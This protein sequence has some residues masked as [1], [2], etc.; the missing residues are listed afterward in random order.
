MIRQIK[1][2]F[3]SAI[4]PGTESA[5]L[6]MGVTNVSLGTPTYADS[7]KSIIYTFPMGSGSGSLGDGIYTITVNPQNQ[8]AQALTFHRLFGDSDGDGDVDSLDLL[9]VKNAT[10]AN[11]SSPAYRWYFDYEDDK[12]IDSVDYAQARA[13]LGMRYVY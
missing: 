3:S 9:A 13:R 7:N 12:D 1:V 11:S 10:S 4:T 8:A 2:T 5:T 6:A